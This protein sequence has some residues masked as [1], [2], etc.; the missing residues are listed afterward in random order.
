MF[1]VEQR[2]EMMRR[3]NTFGNVELACFSGLL[4]EFALERGAT[5]I[6][7]SLRVVMDFDYEYQ[8]TLTNRY[9]VPDVQTVYFPAEQ[10]DTYWNSATIRELLRLGKILPSESGRLSSPHILNGWQKIREES[11]P[12]SFKCFT[13]FHGCVAGASMSH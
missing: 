1:A 5:H 11:E 13:L 10:E 12:W 8:M 7:R 3:V 6:A 4:A 2:L 9:L